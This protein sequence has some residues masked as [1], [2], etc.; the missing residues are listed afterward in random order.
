MTQDPKTSDK[1]SE[2][3]PEA[4]HNGLLNATGTITLS[5]LQIYRF[6]ALFRHSWCPALT[7]AR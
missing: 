2:E 6:T 4:R 3:P 1:Q 7:G 5:A